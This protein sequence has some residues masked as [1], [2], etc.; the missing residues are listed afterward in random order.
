MHYIVFIY[1]IIMSTSCHL[2]TPQR[3]SRW[4]IHILQ[5]STKE[6]TLHITMVHSTDHHHAQ[7]KPERPSHSSDTSYW[8]SSMGN[9]DHRRTSPNMDKATQLASPTSTQTVRQHGHVSRR[10]GV[11]PNVISITSTFIFY[12]RT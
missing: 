8:R 1:L 10:D 6:P 2:A 3:L 11:A 7:T 12:Y 5:T 4:M 9:A